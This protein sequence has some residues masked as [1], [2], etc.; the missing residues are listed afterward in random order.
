MWACC[1]TC[2]SDIANN[3]ALTHPDT[4]LYT[5][6]IL[7][8]MHIAGDIFAV[9]ANF[10]GIATASCPTDADDGAVTD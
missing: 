1:S 5:R 2:C 4:V 3:L 7:G 6:S 8:K 10:D 9:V